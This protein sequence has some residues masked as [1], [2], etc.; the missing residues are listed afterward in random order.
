MALAL[1]WSGSVGAKAE[2][3]LLELCVN[4]SCYGTAFV[5]MQDGHYLVDVESLERAHLALRGGAAQTIEYT[6][7]FD[8]NLLS[9]GIKVDMDQRAGK[10]VLT[11]P[12][13][14]FDGSRI[15]FNS[16]PRTSTAGAVPSAYV[17]YGITG[18]TSGSNSV[19]LD[20][21]FAMGRGLLRDNPS[22]EQ[23][24]G[25][26]R[27]LTR[28]EFDEPDTLARWTVGDQTAS[29]GDGLGGS[30]LL[31]GI[32]IVRAFD[33]N[34]YMLTYP[35]PVITG[36]L[37]SPGTVDIYENGVLVGQRQVPAGPFSLTSLGIGAGA[38]NVR[39][40]VQDP[41]GGSSVLQQ[42]FYGAS[43]LLAPGLSDYAFEVG[44]ERA[45]TLANGYLS[46]RAVLLARESYGF[47]NE[48]TAGIRLEA[49]NGLVNAGP[50]VNL[51]LPVGVL[52]AAV[53][54]SHG[55]DGN[56]Y[57]TSLSY[58]YN[59]RNFSAGAS[60][61]IFSDAYQRI[62][63]DLLEPGERTRRVS[64]ANA[65]WL[66]GRHFNIQLNAGNTVFGTGMKQTN[67]G[68]S[69]EID[70]VGGARIT[71]S[72]NHQV[73]SQGPNDNQVL[74]NFA[75]PLGRSTYGASAGSDQLSGR[76][77]G[78]FA[79]HSVP[80]NAGFGYNVNVQD[81]VVGS[82]GQ[83]Q[84]A[85]QGQYGL[86]Q[87]SAERI[88]GQDT[89]SLLVSGSL[90][91]L[92]G[93]LYAGR[94]LQS[95]YALVETPGLGDV[96]VMS[97]NQPIGRTDTNGNL[98]V[99]NLLP[100]QLN[101]VDINQAT[102]PLDYQMDQINQVISVPRLGGTIV[103]FDIHELH[104]ARGILKVGNDVV[105]YGSAAITINGKPTRT[106]IGLDG[107]FYFSDLPGGKY[108]LQAD[109]AR[110]RLSCPLKVPST[111]GPLIDLGAVRCTVEQAV[112]P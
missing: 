18:G 71:V 76:S 32:G 10:L 98:I 9:A 23:M 28:F 108:V 65:T 55:S 27:G 8:V 112:A 79:Q 66:P 35:Q 99:Y 49:E 58:Q 59:S 82:S 90:V 47:S 11:A 14:A 4:G 101:K 75:V 103:R 94:T 48:V 80:I 15:D 84:L 16:G 95:G 107:S 87:L 106:L 43:Q 20:A 105:K 96:E 73:N 26:S 86:A 53:A 51:R 19:Y 74:L 83:G 13:Q 109:T 102:V 6:K 92:G 69:S 89:E 78:F 45:S 111:S 2:R 104:A 54:G 31:G 57:G 39:V 7:F 37:Q 64:T 93:H 97:Q 70:V 21:G 5:V 1:F 77:Y 33:L 72:F 40:V 3:M 30:A 29:S 46:G 22:W 85:Y 36:M 61:Q 52:S 81:S 24:D 50:S 68:L 56:G 12:P 62:G 88:A 91:A 44:M 17:N 42:N 60:T 67:E 38:N 63:D 100:Y 110:G 34:P 25:F 41:F